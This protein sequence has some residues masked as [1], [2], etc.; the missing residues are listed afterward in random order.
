MGFV[1]VDTVMAMAGSRQWVDLAEESLISGVLIY[2]EG[3]L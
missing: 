3:A 1:I 2:L